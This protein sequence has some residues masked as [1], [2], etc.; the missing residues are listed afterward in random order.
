[1]NRR[2][3]VNIERHQLILDQYSDTEW[4]YISDIMEKT[5]FSRKKIWDITNRLTKQGFL[6]YRD[7]KNGNSHRYSYIKVKAHY[8]IAE[9]ENQE[10]K[11]YSFIPWHDSQIPKPHNPPA[12]AITRHLCR[13]SDSPHLS[14]QDEKQIAQARLIHQERQQAIYKKG[15]Y[16]GRGSYLSEAV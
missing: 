4:L 15:S 1:M 5:G 13:D 7:E 6:N 12:Y 2:S 8:S 10:Q 3:M 14:L 11:E 16:S 9:S